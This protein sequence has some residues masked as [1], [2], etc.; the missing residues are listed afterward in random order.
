MTLT[1]TRLTSSPI[2]HT[3]MSERIGR[4]INGPSL[5]RVPE[6]IE[7]SLGTYYLYFAHH[8]G[9]HIRLAYSDTLAGPWTIHEPGVLD[10]TQ[11]LFVTT[12]LDAPAASASDVDPRWTKGQFLYAH[13]AS[14]DV[15][16][17]HHAK[18]IRMY[19]HGLLEDGD[20]QTR[21]AYSPDGL[22][23]QPRSPLLGPAYFRVFPHGGFI[24]A[25]AW[26]GTLLRARD[27]DGPFECGP[28]LLETSPAVE[29]D[30][31]VRHV[32]VYCRDDQLDLFYSR[33]GDRPEVI[34]HMSIELSADWHDWRATKPMPVLKAELD[35]EGATLPVQASKIGA[36]D[37]PEHAL[38]D[39]CVFVDEGKAYLLYSGAGEQAI[40]LAEMKWPAAGRVT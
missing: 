25:I 24:Y 28:S 19:F 14:P 7:N 34:L 12:D 15:H 35:W 38:R 20:Q 13:I 26:G 22:S 8:K 18:T 10:V 6:W 27:W 31:I 29:G 36:A 1:V 3:E 2:V 17:D 4:N 40:G 11:S 23:F 30:Q 21:V 9:R 33:I 32:A 5:I 39:P 37:G 16:V